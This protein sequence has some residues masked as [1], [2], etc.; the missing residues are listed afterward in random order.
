MLE[1]I[2]SIGNLSDADFEL[3]TSRMEKVTL[4]KG[5]HFLELGKVNMSMGYVEQGLAM[6]YR[7]V[8]DEEVPVDFAMEGNW[9]SYL[10][11]FNSQTPS[12]LGIKMLED[13]TIHCVSFSNL[14]E[15]FRLQP[16]LLALKAYYVEQSLMDMAQ[17]SADLAT[18][19]A[20]ERYYKF[21]QEKPQLFNRIPQYHI[22]AYLGI[23]PQSLS[24][25]RK[26]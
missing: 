26:G 6:Y 14:E 8:N 19:D 15:V 7:I 16:K 1:N 21:M 3:L 10:K 4:S 22:A 24:R 2:K 20:R 17:H 11:S 25:I 5:D 13:S 12:D 18:L 23:K 9:V